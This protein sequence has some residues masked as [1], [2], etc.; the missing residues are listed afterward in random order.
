MQDA[1]HK[2][3]GNL[4]I[5]IEDVEGKLL[6]KFPQL[7]LDGDGYLSKDE[8]TGALKMIFKNP[9]TDEEAQKMITDMDLDG[10][11]QISVAELLKFVEARKAKKDVEAFEVAVKT[12][13]AASEC[14]QRFECCCRS[15][16]CCRGSARHS[17]S[18]CTGRT[19]LSSH[20]GCLI[21]YRKEDRDGPAVQM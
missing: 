4:K 14:K 15:P 8:L 5:K 20:Q 9:P 17:P 21:E 13:K 6:D 18:C 19:A 16:R 10:D 11:G 12:T 1:L 7:D 2:M 3:V